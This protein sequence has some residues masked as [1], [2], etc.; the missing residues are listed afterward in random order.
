LGRQLGFPTANLAV[1]VDQLV[2]SPGVYAGSAGEHLA[3]ISIGVNATVDTN[4]AP[5]VEAYLL[6][7]D[8]N[9][10]DKSL[11]LQFERFLRPMVKFDGLE[12]LIVAIEADVEAVR[13][14]EA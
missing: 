2:P 12:A 6:D 13:N 10:Y 3:A 1:P 8:G 5:T 4:A 7:F 9:L 11:T 14:L